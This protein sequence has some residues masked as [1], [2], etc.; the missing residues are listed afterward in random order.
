MPPQ[1]VCSILPSP[2]TGRRSCSQPTRSFPRRLRPGAHI[3]R[4]SCSAPSTRRGIQSLRDGCVASAASCSTVC[5]RSWSSSAST[6]SAMSTCWAAIC[7]VT[8]CTTGRSADLAMAAGCLLAR[9][10]SRSCATTPST[11]GS[12]P[13][14]ASGGGG[15]AE[16]Q[17]S[18]SRIFPAIEM[19]PGPLPRV[20]R[21][22]GD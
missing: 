14:S 18:K 20:L 11:G 8:V 19:R 17:P 3:L 22:K 10:V 5:I 12:G 21:W 4:Q 1:N 2:Q 16:K 13:R 15:V 7:S 9:L 6:T